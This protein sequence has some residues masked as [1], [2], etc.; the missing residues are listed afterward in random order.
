MRICGPYG[1]VGVVDESDG[2]PALAGWDGEMLGLVRADA[3]VVAHAV[4]KFAALP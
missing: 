4:A 1:E 3:A 2:E